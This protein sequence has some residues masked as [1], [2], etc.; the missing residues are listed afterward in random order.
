MF[1][2]AGEALARHGLKFFYHTHGYEFQPYGKGTL[3]DLLLTETKPRFAA[4]EMDVFWVVH[5]GQ[6]PV[7][8]LKKYPGRW[9][10]THLKGMKDSTPTGLLNGHS[11]VSN[12]VPLGEGKIDYRPFLR[13]AA[14]TGVKWHFIEDESPLVLEQIPKSLRYLERVKW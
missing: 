13:T 9:Q 1:N 14:K 11:D 3:M 4:Y 8:L 10:L 5:A 6:D 12:D 2:K 7:K